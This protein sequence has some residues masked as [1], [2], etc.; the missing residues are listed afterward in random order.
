[1]NILNQYLLSLLIV[2]ELDCDRFL[3]FNCIAQTYCQPFAGF[4]K[5]LNIQTKQ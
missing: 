4:N 1:M 5:N 2:F 3:S